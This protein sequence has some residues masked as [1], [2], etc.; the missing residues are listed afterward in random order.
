MA[1]LE[2][3]LEENGGELTPEL[4]AMWD[5]TKET[6]MRKADGYNTLICKTEAY[7]ENIA[8]EI[9]RLQALKKTADNTAERLRKHVKETMERFN[10]DRIE[11]AFCK[12]WLTRRKRTVIDEDALLRPYAK[13]IEAFEKKLPPYMTVK[14]GIDKTKLK[15]DFGDTDVAPNGVSFTEETS[16]TIR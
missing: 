5:D 3:R 6:L 13:R 1:A 12:M 7:S 9:K 15:S 4:E 16:L 2:E 14:I 11:G 10:V 8:R